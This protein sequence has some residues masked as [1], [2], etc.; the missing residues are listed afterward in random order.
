MKGLN[1]RTNASPMWDIPGVRRSKRI[2]MWILKITKE[3]LEHLK[4]FPNGLMDDMASKT[5]SNCI[6]S[7][8]ALSMKPDLHF[9]PTL[10]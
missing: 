8:T 6:V 3:L 9:Q 7:Y 2:E 1:I 5:I 10:Y 4:V